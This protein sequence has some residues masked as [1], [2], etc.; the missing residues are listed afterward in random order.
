MQKPGR[1]SFLVENY[2]LPTFEI[3]FDS[4]AGQPKLG[5]NVTITGMATSYSGIAVD[6]ATV[7][8]RVIRKTV[9]PWPYYYRNKRWYPPNLNREIEIANGETLTSSDGTG[10][11]EFQFEA[12][13]DNDIP[14]KT[15]PVFYYEI[16]IDVIDIT[17]E[18]QSGNT[19]VRL[20]NKSVILTFEIPSAIELS[21]VNNQ[22]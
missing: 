11:F 5:E 7:R 18:V 22:K 8:Y 15:D 13:P 21:A 9:F 1:V 2:K 16:S 14:A 4:V 10:T 3:V 6:G 19:S 20:G 17:G 12:I